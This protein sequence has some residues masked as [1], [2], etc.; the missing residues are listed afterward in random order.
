MEVDSGSCNTSQH[1]HTCNK[2]TI[3]SLRKISENY[4]C[5]ETS[6]W[7]F[8]G[9]EMTRNTPL[10]LSSFWALLCP[11][12]SMVYCLTH[13]QTRHSHALS[14]FGWLSES[15]KLNDCTHPSII[16]WSERQKI[17]ITHTLN[18]RFYRN[19]VARISHQLTHSTYSVRRVRRVC[20][21]N[22]EWYQLNPLT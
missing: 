8:Y 16:S 1:H 5:S 6:K 12:C 21:Y 17:N 11:D 20:R 3:N 10:S 14:T 19:H 2:W 9:I 4:T 13:C 15:Q 7:L 18:T 22:S